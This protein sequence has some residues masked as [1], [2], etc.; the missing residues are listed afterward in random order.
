MSSQSK[1][2]KTHKESGQPRIEISR[3]KFIE[4]VDIKMTRDSNIRKY[5]EKG[6]RS[7]KNR[8]KRP[9]LN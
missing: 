7:F 3:F 6:L 9:N 5:R 8:Y 2:Y 4:A 1:N